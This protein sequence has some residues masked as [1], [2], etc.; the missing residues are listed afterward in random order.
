MAVNLDFLESQLSSGLWRRSFGDYHSRFKSDVVVECEDV[1][2][3][4]EQTA[5]LPSHSGDPMITG[6]TVWDSA[7]LL[8]WWIIKHPD[9]I[10]QKRVAELGAGT[11]VPGLIAAKLGASEVVLT[12]LPTMVPLIERNIDCYFMQ[13]GRKIW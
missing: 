3:V 8:A 12:D 1:R 6:G 9:V 7:I 11:G 2:I 5:S 10:L 13:G 4:V